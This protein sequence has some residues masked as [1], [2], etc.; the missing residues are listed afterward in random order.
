[1]FYVYFLKS[2]KNGKVYVGKTHQEPKIR[3]KQ[4]NQGANQ[5][6]KA[7]RPLKLVYYET[8]VC[9]EDATNREKF[10]KSGI[11]KRIKR[12]IVKELTKNL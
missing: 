6:T 10:Y 5:W 7:N 8:Y 11:G 3:E 12:S 4:H 1:M 9:K 2:L